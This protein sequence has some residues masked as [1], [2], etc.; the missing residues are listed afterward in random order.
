MC[1][2]DDSFLTEANACLDIFRKTF[3]LQGLSYPI[4]CSM[5][6]ALYPRDTQNTDDLIVYADLAMYKVKKASKNAFCFYHDL[7]Q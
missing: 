2:K 1:D 6:I 7:E 5:G 3:D 4:H